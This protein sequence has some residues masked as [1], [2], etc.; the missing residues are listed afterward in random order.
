[1]G[2]VGLI[3]QRGFIF[4]QAAFDPQQAGHPDL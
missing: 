2:L 3:S 1:M 4:G